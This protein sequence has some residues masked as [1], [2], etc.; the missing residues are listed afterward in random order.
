MILRDEN[1]RAVYQLHPDKLRR[2]RKLLDGRV[3][4]SEDARS[5]LQSSLKIGYWLAYFTEWVI[6]S[7]HG[8]PALQ[9]AAVLKTIGA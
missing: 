9:Q 5:R 4:P 2:A 8:D 7:E 6:L 3:F 1:I